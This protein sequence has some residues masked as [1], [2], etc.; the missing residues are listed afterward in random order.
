MEKNHEKSLAANKL[1]IDLIDKYLL[2]GEISN[3]L[4]SHLSLYF[5]TKFHKSM[6]SFR[7]LVVSGFYEDASIILRTML[8]STITLLYISKSPEE[9]AERFVDYKSI[10]DHKLL[11]FMDE[12]YS[13]HSIKSEQREQIEQAYDTKK[14]KFRKKTQWSNKSL[15][16]MAEEV[17]MTYWYKMMYPFDSSFV[18]SNI[19]A[20]SGFMIE[21]MEGLVV[22][23]GPQAFNATS[24]IS[25]ATELARII[26]YTGAKNFELETDTLEVVCKNV[27]SLIDKEISF[28]H[29][30]E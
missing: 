23:V 28:K 11:Q 16:D 29:M 13:G 2:G 7:L 24:M 26:L 4:I 25:K 15:F 18:H 6:L 17:D 27:K 9:E 20:A 5:L 30:K 3:T 8:E 21:D 22:A 1:M 10:S 14:E 12:Y 19:N